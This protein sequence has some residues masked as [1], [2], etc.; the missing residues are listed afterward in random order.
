MVKPRFKKKHFFCLFSENL[1]G[2]A[3]VRCERGQFKGVIVNLKH[4]L[5]L[6]KNPFLLA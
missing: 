4:I 3:G 1:V 6:V 2:M 5:K